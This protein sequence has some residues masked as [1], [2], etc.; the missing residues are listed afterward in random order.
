M[1]RDGTIDDETRLVF[2][3]ALKRVTGLPLDFWDDATAH[4]SDERLER[5][6]ES[7]WAFR[8]DDGKRPLDQPEPVR[9]FI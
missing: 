9:D 1:A 7:Y 3:R 2:L 4:I 8:R 5:L 6:M